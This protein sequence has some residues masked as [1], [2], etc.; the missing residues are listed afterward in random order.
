M[1][2]IDTGPHHHNWL[3]EEPIKIVVNM[4]ITMMLHKYLR[5]P[6]GNIKPELWLMEMNHTVWLYNRTP[7]P[8][9]G[10]YTFEVW[11]HY[12]FE[13]VSE[14]FSCCHVRVCPTYVLDPKLYKYGFKIPK[15][16]PR[17]RQR[18]NAGFSGMYSSLV[19]LVLNPMTGSI[20][21]HFHVVYDDLLTIMHLN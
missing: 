18:V 9:T 12:S 15:F 2:F 11:S 20:S 13:M 8:Q 17:I 6:E 3:S 4:K 16:P 7:N 1:E 19:V 14:N 10:L 5:W 21:H